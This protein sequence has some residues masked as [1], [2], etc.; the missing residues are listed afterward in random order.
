[1]PSV[2]II[3]PTFNRC[4]LVSQA[5]QSVLSG[6]FRDFEILVVDDG[7][8]DQTACAIKQLGD[9]RIKYIYKK[10]GGQSSARNLGL[11]MALGEYIAFLDAD[12]LWP[13]NVLETLTDRLK[14]DTRYGAAYSRVVEL[15]PDGTK[16]DLSKPEYCR[17]G[18]ITPY[19]V[20]RMPC[21]M[22]S[23]ILFRRSAWKDMF[24]DEAIKKGTDYDVFLRISTRIQFLFVPDIFI[25]KRSMPDSLS[26]RPDPLGPVYKALTLE[27]FYIN[28]QGQNIIPSRS[29]RRKISHEYRKSAII[30][31]RLQN[32]CAGLQFLKQAIRWRPLDIRLY[33][34]LMKIAWSGNN[35]AADP[36]HTVKKLPSHIT[37][38]CSRG[39]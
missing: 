9:P 22:P 37:V 16:K 18:W 24:W 26:K 32:R 20:S 34:D 3:I 28:Y 31:C 14:A 4:G 23:A 2:S 1:M 17:S 29:I 39:R 30:S 35:E 21:L 19:F 36:W 38:S 12:D 7:S 8:T 33:V 11:S 25:L 15:Y 6:R 13:D 5:C 10:N 27:R